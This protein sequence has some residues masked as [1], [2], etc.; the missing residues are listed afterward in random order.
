HYLSSS[1]SQRSAQLNSKDSAFVHRFRQSCGGDIASID[2][3]HTST[4]R[5]ETRWFFPCPR[6]EGGVQAGAGD[7]HAERSSKQQQQA[8]GR[9]RGAGGITYDRESGRAGWRAGTPCPSRPAPAARDLVPTTPAPDIQD[10]CVANRASGVQ[11][12][13]RQGAARRRR[14]RRRRRLGGR[15]GRRGRGRGGAAAARARALAKESDRN[16][17]CLAAA[18]AARA[19][20]AAFARLASERVGV[21]PRSPARWRRPGRAHRVLPARRRGPPLHC[22]P[23]SLKSLVS[24]MSHGE[25]Q[26]RASAASCSASRVVV[27]GR[28]RHTLEAVQRPQACWTRSWTSS[29]APSPRRPPRPRSSRLLLVAAPTARRRASRARRGGGARGGLVDA[30]KG[31]SEK[32]LAALDGVLCADAGLAAAR[33]HALAVPVLVKKMFACPTWPRTSRLRALA[34][35]PRGR[36]RWRRRVPRR[37]GPRRRF[38][39]LLLRS[40]SAAAASPRSAPASC[41]DAQRLQRQ[42]RVHRDRRLQGTQEAILIG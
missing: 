41:S 24:V 22:L 31:T 34:P 42:R 28:R 33:A 29:G 10:W 38:Q 19:L 23:S 40:R 36:R 39:K 9:R 15:R 7:T 4:G 3:N 17:R 37:G 8:S 16:R 6:S 12:C 26:A 11:R 14:R 2:K 18:G 1:S 21:P 5:P 30:D 13:P 25:L 35:L 32:A 20:A 27:V